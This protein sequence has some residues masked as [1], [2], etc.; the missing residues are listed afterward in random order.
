M[1]DTPNTDLGARHAQL[2]EDIQ[3]ASEVA[4][5]EDRELSKAETETVDELNRQL[6]VVEERI[7]FEADL[8]DRRAKAAEGLT[9][10]KK[11]QPP[12]TAAKPAAYDQ[13][14][15]QADDQSPVYRKGGEHSF[16]ID[17]AMAT[18]GKLQRDTASEKDLRSAEERIARYKSERVHRDVDTSNI[19]GLVPPNYLTDQAL[20]FVRSGAPFKNALMSR[21]MPSYGTTI[22]VN[23]I[24]TGS[25]ADDEPENAASSTTDI[26]S[27][28]V[29]LPVRTVR[30]A[31]ELSFE[32][33]YRGVGVDEAFYMDLAAAVEQKIDAFLINGTGS[34]QISGILKS[35]EI[36][37]GNIKTDA[38]ESTT[39]AT[40]CFQYIVDLQT[41]LTTSR[42]QAPTL[43]LLHPRR[44]G[45]LVKGVD[46]DQR[47]LFAPAAMTATNV[48]G[49]GEHTY[50]ETMVSIGGTPV[51]TDAA[52]PTT[53][54][55]NTQ[56][57]AIAV[58]AP[59]CHLYESP[60][61][62]FTGDPK[63]HN[64]THT[65]TMGKF[66]AFKLMRTSGAATVRGTQFAAV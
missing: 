10:L 22:N 18:P 5:N 54:A 36:A 42:F 31:I 20:G 52:V 40:K 29:Q 15:R 11:A 55:T 37:T 46:G 26:D 1:A 43:F 44:L 64:W 47:P 14:V 45:Y 32:S 62:V 9:R 4:A 25:T 51:V 33:M 39:T 8:A 65:I 38:D 16:F 12:Q 21:S 49:L 66:V 24:D 7:S 35:G 57:V 34:N 59:D 27:V 30:G 28:N 58:F 6:A 61:M 48:V 60:M 19:P 2:V 23:R 3:R 53:Y 13:V 56:D 63:L 41:K 50:G 17:L